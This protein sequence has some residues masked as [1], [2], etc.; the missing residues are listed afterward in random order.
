[1][2][3]GILGAG[4]GD[5]FGEVISLSGDGNSLATGSVQYETFSGYARVY[6][7]DS[8]AGEWL[9]SGGDIV[10]EDENDRSAS[11]LSLSSDGTKLC[12]VA[13]SEFFPFTLMGKQE[14]TE[15]AGVRTFIVYFVLFYLWAN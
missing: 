4:A 15:V 6:R 5:N 3:Q 7:Y 13:M 14:V 8:D 9:Q 2:G 10:G 12:I 1:V 11:S